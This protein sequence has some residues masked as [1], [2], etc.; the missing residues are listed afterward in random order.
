MVGKLFYLLE[1]SVKNGYLF[2]KRLLRVSGEASGLGFFFVS[3][4]VITNS[5]SPFVRGLFTLSIFNQLHYCLSRDPFHLLFCL[6]NTSV[7]VFFKIDFINTNWMVVFPFSLI[8]LIFRGFPLFI[9]LNL[10]TAFLY[11]L[12]ESAFNFSDF[13]YYVPIISALLSI[14]SFLLF[15]F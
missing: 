10:A 7:T 4:S 1:G 14:I 15:S 8:I 12:K 3:N 5:I 9:L 2:F 11:F 13:L 6:Q